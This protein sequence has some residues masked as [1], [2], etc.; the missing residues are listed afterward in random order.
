MSPVTIS[1]TIATGGTI[2]LNAGGSLGIPGTISITSGASGG[3][4]QRVMVLAAPPPP[5]IP[6]PSAVTTATVRPVGR[7]P[8][9]VVNPALGLVPI[10]QRAITVREGGLVGLAGPS[11]GMSGAI[12][13]TLDKLTIGGA[14]AL[15]VDLA[16]DGLLRLQVARPV[17]DVHGKPLSPAGG[18][19]TLSARTA[20]DVVDGVTNAQG[21]AAAHS[22]A[23]EGG[24]IVFGGA[25]PE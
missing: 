17:V 16:G 3:G 21:R 13:A 11:S 2:T 24:V 15:T 8:S 18:T 14:D 25:P 7:A 19:A 9:P 23:N 4:S 6:P 22:V 20:R 1:G 12:I 5:T 10:D